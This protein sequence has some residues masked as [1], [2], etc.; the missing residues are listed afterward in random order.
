MARGNSSSAEVGT[1]QGQEGWPW[2]ERVARFG[3]AA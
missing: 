2:I 1:I 3:Y